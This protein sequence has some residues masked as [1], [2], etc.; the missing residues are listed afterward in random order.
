MTVEI[1]VKF[2]AND[3]AVQAL[4]TTLAQWPH[5]AFPAQSLTNIYFETADNQLRRWDMGLRIRGWDT[6]FEM[7]LKTAGQTVGGLHQRAEYN[8]PLQQAVLDIAQ[9]PADVWPAG[10]DVSALQQA[11]KPLFSTHFVRTTW[12]VTYLNSEIE[13]AFDHGE[14]VA[15]ELTTPLNE[16]ELELKS[17]ERDDLLAF[18]AQLATL[19]GLRLGS[20]SKAARGYWLA[21]GAPERQLRPFPVLA[22]A[23]KSSVEQGMQAALQLA[24]QQWQYHEE[25]WLQGNKQAR[26]GIEDAL[27]AIRQVFTLCGAL[28]PRKANSELRQK[29]TLLEE[30]LAS[31]D[32]QAE[33]VNTPIS[34]DAQLALTHWLVTAHWQSFVDEKAKKRLADSFKRFADVMLG[35]IAADLR[36]TFTQVT[37][38]SAF[39]DKQLR[40]TRQIL[41]AKLL[42]GAYDQHA[43]EAWLTQ[44]QQLS[45]AITYSDYRLA[46][47]SSQ[48]AIRLAPFW[49]SSSSQ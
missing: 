34:V 26:K 8:V 46:K 47:E 20:Q 31:A 12:L 24:L 35:R 36:D 41:A 14:V 10:T 18:A 17:G 22:I 40:L 37:L 49:K 5:Q 23:P 9:L 15:G 1:E 39:Q 45:Q 6:E 27:E 16:I 7:T 25:L 32:V 11:L 48:A 33:I 13:V 44:W 29:L 19:P 42:A 21:Q 38:L 4:P 30:Q 3:Q 43:V 28:V 2:I